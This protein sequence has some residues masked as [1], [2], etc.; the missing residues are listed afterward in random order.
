[1]ALLYGRA[2]RLTTKSGGFRP[3]QVQ[4]RIAACNGSQCGFC[5]PGQVGRLG[6]GRIVA[7]EIEVPNMLGYYSICYDNKHASI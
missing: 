1:M 2:D 6:F 5:T 4:E 7:S 3:G